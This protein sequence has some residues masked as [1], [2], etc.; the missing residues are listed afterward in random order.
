M[1][2]C[3]VDIAYVLNSN[4]TI[5]RNL[6]IIYLRIVVSCMACLEMLWHAV[7]HSWLLISKPTNAHMVHTHN[8]HCCMRQAHASIGVCGG[9]L[10]KPISSSHARCIFV[11]LVHVPAW[12]EHLATPD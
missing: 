2:T 9:K 7:A 12:Y 1:Y 5:Y 11:G 10:M 3:I 6:R 4:V 8:W